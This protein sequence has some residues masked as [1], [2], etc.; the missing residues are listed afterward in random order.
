MSGTLNEGFYAGHFM[1]SE[2]PGFR[3]RDAGTLFNSTGAAVT[4]EAGLVLARDDTA[5]PSS[6]AKSGGNTGNGTMGAITVAQALK[7][8]VYTVR[9]L[10]ATTFRVEDPDG[11]VLG[12]GATG[13][14]FGDDMSFTI[15]AGG[16]P[17]VAGDGF[18]ITVAAGT[19]R[20][21]PFTNAVNRPA[22]GILWDRAVVPATGTARRTVVTRDAE[23]N[24]AELRWDPSLS[25]GALTAAQA[26]ARASLQAAG[27]VG[28]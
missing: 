28:R 7:L 19:G 22:V 15:T 2:G 12:D 23:V 27:I 25:G 26:A 8:G 4:M 21:I 18:D 17:F 14:A 24:W 13:V 16:T 5:A 20:F 11:F 10:T 9:M 1:V 3:S 6:A